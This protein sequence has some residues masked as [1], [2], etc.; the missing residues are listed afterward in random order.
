ML[1][2]LHIIYIIYTL[3]ILHILHTLHTLY[4]LHIIYI[5]YLVYLHRHTYISIFMRYNLHRKIKFTITR[6]FK[7]MRASGEKII[8]KQK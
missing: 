4:I 8:K 5:I 1:H 2:T 6:H 3:P 7:K